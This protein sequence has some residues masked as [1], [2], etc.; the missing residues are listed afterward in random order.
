MLNTILCSKK[1]L[2]ESKK[3]QRNEMVWISCLP[4]KQECFINRYNPFMKVIWGKVIGWFY[5][6]LKR[7]G[8]AFYS[9]S[10]VAPSSTAWSIFA[11]SLQQIVSYLYERVAIAYCRNDVYVH[12]T[13]QV[14][15]SLLAHTIIPN[16]DSNCQR[17]ND[18]RLSSFLPFLSITIHGF[19]QDQ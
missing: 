5:A 10:L 15:Q 8:M 2:K 3:K 14:L 4:E 7:S 16:M 17:P 19:P 13:F 12:C 9:I 1:W 11:T 18:S 6:L